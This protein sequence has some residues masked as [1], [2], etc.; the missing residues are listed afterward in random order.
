MRVLPEYTC[1]HTRKTLPLLLPAQAR[2][3]LPLGWGCLR[4]FFHLFY[5]AGIRWCL[6]PLLTSGDRYWISP[7]AFTGSLCLALGRTRLSEA[8]KALRQ[9]SHASDDL[10][11]TQTSSTSST[12]FQPSKLWHLPNLCSLGMS[13]Q[14]KGAQFDMPPRKPITFLHLLP[15]PNPTPSVGSGISK[16]PRNQIHPDFLFIPHAMGGWINPY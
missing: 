10:G 4:V 7:S 16:I 11:A 14:D 15:Q 2:H 13:P 1:V 6:M 12:G 8:G 3:C 9:V 5:L